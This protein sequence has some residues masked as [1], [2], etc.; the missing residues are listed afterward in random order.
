MATTFPEALE[1]ALKRC[2]PLTTQTLEG[3]LGGLLEMD[4]EQ[5]SQLPGSPGQV[6]AAQFCFYARSL[7]CL[8]EE[9]RRRPGAFLALVDALRRLPAAK[10]TTRRRKSRGDSSRAQAVGG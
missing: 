2:P 7:A 3:F 6:L 10:S 4:L 8:E 5:L 1:F 9:V